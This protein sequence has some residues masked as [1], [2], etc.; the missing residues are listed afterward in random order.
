[1]GVRRSQVAIELLMSYGWIM[2]AVLAWLTI[3]WARYGA[4]MGDPEMLVVAEMVVLDQGWI[5]LN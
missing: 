5:R 2:V 3:Q 4:V 1:M